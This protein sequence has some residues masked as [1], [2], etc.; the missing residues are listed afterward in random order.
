LNGACPAGATWATRGTINETTL[1]VGGTVGTPYTISFEVRGVLGTRCYV[2][3]VAASTAAPNPNGPNNTWYVGGTQYNDSIWNTFEVHVLNPGG[4]EAAVY[5]A[6]AF[7]INP[8]WCEREATYQIGYMASFGVIGGGSILFRIHDAN[9]QMQQ[10]C[11]PNEASTTCDAP[12]T[13]A[14]SDLSPPPPP[15]FVQP[16][17]IASAGKNYYTQWLYFDVKNVTTP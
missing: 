10:N 9:C 14:V 12:R 6:N 13:I 16:R 15:N 3:G 1:T 8:N 11:G 4:A 2:G 5:Y 17:A 7:P